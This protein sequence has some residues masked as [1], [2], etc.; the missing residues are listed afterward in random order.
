[1]IL[2][3]FITAFLFFLFASQFSLAQHTYVRNLGPDTTDERGAEVI[4]TSD[5]HYLFVG[6][7]K[8]LNEDKLNI[9]LA[10]YTFAGELVWSKK[11]ESPYHEDPRCIT[12]LNDGTGFII[13]GLT[14]EFSTDGDW[15]IMRVD[16]AGNIVWKKYFVVESVSVVRK[17]F[18]L[19]DNNFLTIGQV[20]GLLPDVPKDVDGAIIKISPNGDFLDTL[21]IPEPKRIYIR[22]ATMARD[23][24]IV[25]CGD[26]K[27]PNLW[28]FDMYVVKLDSTF[29]VEFTKTYTNAKDTRA[30]SITQLENGEYFAVGTRDVDEYDKD[31]FVIRI[32]SLG[33]LLRS[34]NHWQLRNDLFFD[35]KQRKDGKMVVVGNSGKFMVGG[36]SSSVGVWILDTSGVM[37]KRNVFGSISRHSSGNNFK[38]HNDSLLVI[39]GYG[40]IN[41]DYSAST[42][43]HYYDNAIIARTDTNGFHNSIYRTKTGF[44]YGTVEIGTSKQDTLYIVNN[45]FHNRH[46]K[47][48]L[49]SNNPPGIFSLI[50]GLTSSDTLFSSDTLRIIG[51]FTPNAVKIDS[52]YFNFNY[53][54]EGYPPSTQ[55]VFKFYGEGIDSIVPIE[56]TNFKALI[57][58]NEVLLKWE[59]KTELNNLGFE[60]Q[61]KIA[62]EE[63]VTLDFINGFG[64]TTE[65]RNY[66]FTDKNLLPGKYIYRLKQIDFDGTYSYS[67]EVEVEVEVELNIPTKFELYQNYPNPFNPSTTIKFG[68]PKD[69]KVVL[70]VYN[71]VGQKVTTLINNESKEA[72]YHQVN[73]NAS[74]LSSGIYLYKLTTDNFTSI[75]KFVLMK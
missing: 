26:I 8:L 68:L 54:V 65:I 4:I 74:S 50:E 66:S 10:K 7:T 59:T 39:T 19:D 20:Y 61:R 62:V 70:D 57:S 41:S 38:I 11:L 49:N 37:L 29:Q 55:I 15:L 64:T 34:Y 52:G 53:A 2:R 14:K 31:P 71:I 69:S 72:G 13:G 40:A 3:Y 60:I 24:G 42:G 27:R 1:M 35:V 44:N 45:G 25:L 32:D 9:I 73:F 22:G 67:F 5:G 43:Y 6:T 51:K 23:G 48:F 12:E 47:V 33:N 18:M 16:L 58:G 75:K 56:L 30:V 21:I 63:F 46:Y 28:R 17:I 36:A